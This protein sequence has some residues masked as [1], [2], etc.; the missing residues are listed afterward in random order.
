MPFQR[1]AFCFENEWVKFKMV[2]GAEKLGL[3]SIKSSGLE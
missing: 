3:W 1:T 2:K